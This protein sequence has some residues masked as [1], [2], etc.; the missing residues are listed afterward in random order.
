[1]GSV[2]HSTSMQQGEDGS[3]TSTSRSQ[4]RIATAHHQQQLAMI[5]AVD[6]VGRTM[7]DK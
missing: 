5:E 1:M 4:N 2:Q 6:D 3:M 7:D